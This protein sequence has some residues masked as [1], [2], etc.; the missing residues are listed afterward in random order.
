[1]ANHLR[2]CHFVPREGQPD[3]PLLK[4]VQPE[5]QLQDPVYIQPALTWL[6]GFRSTVLSLQ[7]LERCK[8]MIMRSS[9]CS[10]RCFNSCYM[11]TICYSC[12][13][14][15]FSVAYGPQ[16]R[17]VTVPSNLHVT[18][19]PPILLGHIS[20]WYIMGM[21]CFPRGVLAWLEEELGSSLADRTLGSIMHTSTLLQDDW[22]IDLRLFKCYDIS[23]RPKFWFGPVLWGSILVPRNPR[24]EYS[25]PQLLHS[26]GATSPSIHNFWQVGTA[27]HQLEGPIHDLVHDLWQGMAWKYP[28][29]MKVGISITLILL[30]SFGKAYE[31]V[32]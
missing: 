14:A 8:Q 21:L 28:T 1:M 24:V 4:G 22:M 10:M 2:L 29:L 6:V 32:V 13:C 25:H 19:S 5:T 20:L 27:I 30:L 7:M 18:Q 23:F 3:P 16:T 9:W 15:C 31:R 17:Y 11:T 12:Q 26:H